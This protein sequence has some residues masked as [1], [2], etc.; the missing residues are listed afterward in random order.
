MTDGLE[1]VEQE[2]GNS[3]ESVPTSTTW[4][5]EDENWK[6]F[7]VEQSTVSV[8]GRNGPHTQD[9]IFGKFDIAKHRDTETENKKIYSYIA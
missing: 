8:R 4:T 3:I 2:A 7:N 1:R 5:R 6:T 9:I